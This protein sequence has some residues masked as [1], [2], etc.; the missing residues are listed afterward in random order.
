MLAVTTHKLPFFS[1][2]EIWFYDGR[3]VEKG[4][5]T[6]YCYALKA[7]HSFDS[8]LE[9][10]SARIDL[11]ADINTLF[12]NMNKSYQYEVRKAQD[13]GFQVSLNSNPTRAECI[14]FLDSFNSFAKWK[15]APPPRRRRILAL[16]RAGN[17]I[18]TS[19][20]IEQQKL[21]THVYIHDSETALL[22]HS[23]HEKDVC[24]DQKRAIA[25]KFLHWQDIIYF[26]E[27]GFLTYDLGGINCEIFPGISQFKLG[28]GATPYNVK[29]Y[30]D[31]VNW[32]KPAYALYRKLR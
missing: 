28:L 5:Y 18:L 19:V 16:Q 6:V 22:L 32:L 2:K 31:K 8:Y 29:N 13:A 17:L 20:K 11:S 9:E 7:P 24:E 23:Y 10:Q 26:K 15:K 1:K 30:I 12:A 21:I 4:S 14:Q 27:N 25:N 3:S